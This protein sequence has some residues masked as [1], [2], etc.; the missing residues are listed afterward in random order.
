LVKDL[1]MR[2]RGRDTRDALSGHDPDY[3]QKRVVM[4]S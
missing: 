4:S 3:S 2:P 1:F